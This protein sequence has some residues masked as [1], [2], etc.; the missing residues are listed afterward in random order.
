MI[1]HFINKY[2]NA[3]LKVFT[4]TWTEDP[5]G[6]IWLTNAI[7]YDYE[8]GTLEDNDLRIEEE[9]EG[10]TKMREKLRQEE[11]RELNEHL[12]KIIGTHYSKMRF[13]MQIN[14]IKPPSFVDDNIWPKDLC[15]NRI[16]QKDFK[17]LEA[18]FKKDALNTNKI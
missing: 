1:F 5:K 4:C 12:H 8:E 17:K 7:I 3:I 11:E 2:H 16:Y 15:I 13:V 18:I 14:K 10:Q 9:D 6:T